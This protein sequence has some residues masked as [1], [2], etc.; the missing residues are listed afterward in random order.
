MMVASYLELRDW[1]HQ[2]TLCNGISVTSDLS[3]LLVLGNSFVEAMRRQ[4]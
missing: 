2:E 4:I 1:I 3:Q